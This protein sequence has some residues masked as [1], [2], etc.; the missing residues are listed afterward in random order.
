MSTAR[1]READPVWEKIFARTQEVLNDPPFKE[2]A[3]AIPVGPTIT[4]PMVAGPTILAPQITQGP[5][6][7][8]PRALQVRPI[9]PAVALR[10]TARI[11]QAIRRLADLDDGELVFTVTFDDGCGYLVGAPW[12]NGYESPFWS[13]GEIHMLETVNEWVNSEFE[14]VMDRFYY[15]ECGVDIDEEHQI[16]ASV[17]TLQDAWET[18]AAGEPWVTVTATITDQA[19]FPIE[20]VTMTAGDLMGYW[21][22][23]GPIWPTVVIADQVLTQDYEQI[24]DDDYAY[25]DHGYRITSVDRSSEEFTIV[26]I[27]P[28]NN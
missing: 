23:D 25:L 21:G 26:H 15:E 28:T 11:Q 6:V 2:V 19:G 14:A 3:L 7:G 1:T 16:R 8:Q 22:L 24:L 12:E 4:A 20:V 10:V 18:V 9:N 13:A 17:E 5:Q 27:S